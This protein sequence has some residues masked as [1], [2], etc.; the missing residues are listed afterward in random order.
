MQSCDQRQR[1]DKISR[2]FFSSIL[3]MYNLSTWTSVSC[4]VIK[5]EVVGQAA[6]AMTTVKILDHR[7][8]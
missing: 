5:V 6:I 1:K 3:V 8:G 2:R 4:S 7:S